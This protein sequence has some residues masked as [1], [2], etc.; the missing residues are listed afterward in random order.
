MATVFTSWKEIAQYLGK[1]VRT[2]QRWEQEAGL[3][4]RRQHGE[5]KGKVLAFAEEIEG[6]KHSATAQDDDQPERIRLLEE[7]ERLLTENEDMRRKLKAVQQ[8]S[9]PPTNVLASSDERLFSRCRLL[10]ADNARCR[11]T[12]AG[13]IETHSSL[14]QASADIMKALKAFHPFRPD[15]LSHTSSK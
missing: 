14:R 6:W 2:A 7:V 11:Q 5:G 3:P 10:L 8:A 13:L 12:L 15:V 4:V 1:G 9:Y